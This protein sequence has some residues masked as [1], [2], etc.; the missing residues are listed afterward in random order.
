MYGLFRVKV[1]PGRDKSVSA[2]PLLSTRAAWAPG[3][4]RA[5]PTPGAGAPFGSG[6]VPLS[7]RALALC[8]DCCHGWIGTGCHL[9][10]IP[11]SGD[12][13][14]PLHTT[15]S[16]VSGA[17]LAQAVSPGG[18]VA[19]PGR[20]RAGVGAPWWPAP[21]FLGADRALLRSIPLAAGK[22]DRELYLIGIKRRISKE[23]QRQRALKTQHS[24]AVC[25]VS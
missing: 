18:G 23:M 19:R 5:L 22:F 7:P 20:Q 12:L 4:G 16:H 11:E 24:S 15:P 25:T 3:G 14:R 9:G 2:R 17:C 1:R 21:P 13:A 8:G 10:N 6:C